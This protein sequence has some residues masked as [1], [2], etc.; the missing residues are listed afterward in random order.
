MRVT[1]AWIL[2]LFAAFVAPALLM[3]QELKTINKPGVMVGNAATDDEKGKPLKIKKGEKVT[4]IYSRDD[5]MWVKTKGG[6]AGWVL[7][8]EVKV[9]D[10]AADA[11]DDKKK[12]DDKATKQAAAEE[13][14]KKK[15]E[16]KAA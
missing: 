14:K 16:E 12:D 13:A 11:S 8:K 9:L 4:V 10:A 15:E 2:V 5:W 6:R 3:A 7:K 1:R